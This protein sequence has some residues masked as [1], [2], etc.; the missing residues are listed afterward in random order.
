MG[1]RSC[2][3]TVLREREAV[4]HLNAGKH[5][6][7]DLK[8]IS[9]Y[10]CTQMHTHTHTLQL[11]PQYDAQTSN[12][13]T[14]TVEQRAPKAGVPPLPTGCEVLTGPGGGCHP[15]L[16]APIG[17]GGRQ[18]SGPTP[19]GRCREQGPGPEGDAGIPEWTLI[20]GHSSTATKVCMGNPMMN[21]QCD[22]FM[23]KKS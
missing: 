8:C 1:G 13:P 11:C 7:H 6:L 22:G 2:I 15:H 9:V 16:W 12:P 23:G 5:L 3:S 4:I 14:L 19:W 17:R 18:G 20:L 21:E 10:L